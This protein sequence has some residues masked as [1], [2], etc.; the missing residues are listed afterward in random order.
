MSVR[1]RVSITIAVSSSSAE[2]KDLGNGAYQVVTDTPNDGGSWKVKVPASTTNMQIP[3]AGIAEV[4]FVAFRTT[5]YDPTVPPIDLGFRKNST[6]GELQTVSPINNQ[7][8]WY[9]ISTDTIEAM[10]V[11][12]SGATDMQVTIFAWGV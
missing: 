6:S 1:G 10:Y 9:L 7:E 4:A 2:E 5:S 8:G 11:T 12:N 3:F